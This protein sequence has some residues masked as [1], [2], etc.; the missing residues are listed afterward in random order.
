LDLAF[1]RSPQPPKPILS[2]ENAMIR[3]NGDTTAASD[4]LMALAQRA[5]VV[6]YVSRH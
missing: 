1:G 4:D 2:F 5:K 6:E 3:M